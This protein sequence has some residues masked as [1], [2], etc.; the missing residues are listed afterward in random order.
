MSPTTSYSGES[1][2]WMPPASFLMTT[3]AVKIQ[4]MA[5]GVLLTAGDPAA[6]SAAAAAATAATAPT[7]LLFFFPQAWARR[8]A[9]DTE[10]WR[11]S[12]LPSAMHAVSCLLGLLGSPGLAKVVDSLTHKGK[13]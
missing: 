3:T 6:V 9:E 2:N 5:H 13:P 7:A 12:A 1:W 10:I 8:M 11:T 4:D